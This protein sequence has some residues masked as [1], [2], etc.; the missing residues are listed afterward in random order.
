MRVRL[1]EDYNK[2][3]GKY[4]QL[5]AQHEAAALEA[6]EAKDQLKEQIEEIQGRLEIREVTRG[7]PLG[8]SC[9]IVER[10]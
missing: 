4:N 6:D 8:R 10:C 2:V 3:V 5:K 7:H 1:E 9:S